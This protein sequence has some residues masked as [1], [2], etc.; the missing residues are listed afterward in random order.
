MYFGSGRWFAKNDE[1]EASTNAIYGVPINTDGTDISA[2]QLI[3]VTNINNTGEIC[4]NTGS[5]GW[6]INLLNSDSTNKEGKEKIITDPTGSDNIAVFV[7]IRPNSDVCSLGGK[8]RVWTLN[9]AT[10][11]A[12]KGCGSGSKSTVE[13]TIL[14]QLSGGDIQQIKMDKDTRVSN[15]YT[16]IAPENAPPIIKYTGSYTGEILLWLEK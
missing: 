4:S 13:G 6:Y 2:P 7:S 12:P 3:D 14:L 15:W 10:G 11:G 16:G 8:T 9:C 5:Y 1:W